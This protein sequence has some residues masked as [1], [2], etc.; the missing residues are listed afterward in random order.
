MKKLLKY[1][2][3]LLVTLEH[4]SAIG[5]PKI[6][7]L[8]MEQPFPLMGKK[9]FNRMTLKCQATGNPM[10][11]IQ[12]KLNGKILTGGRYY[13]PPSEGGESQLNVFSVTRAD[14]GSYRC[15]ATNKYGTIFN[16]I[17]VKIYKMGKFNPPYT[18]YD[19]PIKQE[20]H[21]GKPL[22][23]ACPDHDEGIGNSYVWGSMP[24]SG[25]PT[26][27]RSG[28]EP[29]EDGF[30]SSHGELVF[31]T[32]TSAKVKLINDM[33]GV[34][35][36][37]YRSEPVSSV[38][39]QL[40]VKSEEVPVNSKPQL[41]RMIDADMVG[42]TGKNKEM[43]CG[44][45]G[46]PNPKV[47]W[48]KDG[49]EITKLNT[50][51]EGRNFTISGH[52]MTLTIRPITYL[53]EGKYK[54]VAENSEG[55]DE[56]EGFLR[57]H[58]KPYFKKD[59]DVLQKVLYDQSITLNCEGTGK[60]QVTFDWYFNGSLLN[61]TDRYDISG[62]KLTILK[63]DFNHTGLYLCVVRN[64]L[65]LNVQPAYVSVDA[66]PPSIT[67]GLDK[68][69]YIFKGKDNLLSCTFYSAPS[70]LITWSKADANIS[71]S[72]EK[73]MLPNVQDKD[74]GKYT[75]HAKNV[76]GEDKDV[77]QVYAVVETV[78]TKKPASL[79]KKVGTKMAQL[80]CDAV[81]EKKYLKGTFQWLRNGQPFT[82]S[83]NVYLENRLT[84]P[85]R[86]MFFKDIPMSAAG[87]YTCRVYAEDSSRRIISEDTAV[88]SITV[89]GKPKSPVEG[90]LTGDCDN[91][92]N[93]LALSWK[94][95]NYYGQNI[96]YYILEF[97]ARDRSADESA[98]IRYDPD[99]KIMDES[100]DIEV[101][102]LPP[103]AD[104]VFR[105][106]SVIEFDDEIFISDPLSVYG[107]CSTPA[108]APIW[109]PKIGS[110]SDGPGTLTVTWNDVDD[111]MK[112]GPGFAI[113]VD[114]KKLPD[115]E[116]ITKTITNGNKLV[117]DNAGE[118]EEYEVTVRAKNDHGS[119]PEVKAKLKSSG[120]RITSAPDG[121]E[122]EFD[123]VTNDV[124]I[125]WKP[126]EGA[127]KYKVYYSAGATKRRR[128][129][130]HGMKEMVVETVNATLLAKDL[131]SE[132][133]Y[134]YQIAGAND[135]MDGPKS[136]ES[137]FQTKPSV[138][139]APMDADVNIIG[140][141]IHVTWNPPA[142]ERTKI[143]GYVVTYYK[144][145][146]KSNKKT[147]ECDADC[148]ELFVT[149]GLDPFSYYTVE[150]SAKNENGIGE[151]QVFDGLVV[152]T[153]DIPGKPAP[154][155]Y[156]NLNE[157]TMAINFALPTKGYVG[158][159][160]KTFT[161]HYYMHGEDE[162]T[163]LKVSAEF[164]SRENITIHNVEPQAYVLFAVGTNQAGT[165]ERSDVTERY[166][167]KRVIPVTVKDVPSEPFYEKIWFLILIIIIALIILI[168]LII[169]CCLTRRGGKYPVDEKE[170]E[171][172]G[173][174]NAPLKDYSEVPMDEIASSPAKNGKGPIR[175]AS[176]NSLKPPFDADEDEDKD[177][178]DD[179][180]ED[181]KFNEDG[182]FIGQYGG[183]DAKKSNTVNGGAVV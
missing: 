6:T 105:L 106:K 37:L 8:E 174:D 180:G 115:G 14:E 117:I 3:T 134:T 165:G 164:P 83:K 72:G 141:G 122:V 144:D 20:A 142:A 9:G 43:I 33:G 60:P 157:T 126:V 90:S 56:K 130:A 108:G 10:P 55:K 57:V 98:W 64:Y 124:I 132:T 125:S 152:S 145:G 176:Q 42:V 101:K 1:I 154:P 95:D 54:C 46:Y 135:Y 11:T 110:E 16:E 34:S 178:L 136:P 137:T 146:D 138:P 92:S 53:A 161:I 113:V 175:S 17:I 12:W 76:K 116:T 169:C 63:A 127:T 168:A 133:S 163:A 87:G 109:V 7:Y 61:K 48:Y 170:R 96:S 62:G 114:Y 50:N 147:M 51:T 118:N 167:V 78:I 26:M 39:I 19:P 183:E 131:K 49:V 158:G 65:G 139:K 84:G 4:A 88:G 47:T 69:T 24:D 71:S 119:G 21:I 156:V 59:M 102:K 44:A 77:A 35:C 45:I 155:T 23:L 36:I 148:R 52:G 162:S 173:W 2:T 25:T 67:S 97:A 171:R 94:Q 74:T 93:S 103:S 177:S 143:T 58:S 30:F 99:T 31:S 121:I 89:I 15:E 70:S 68:P 111:V 13:T 166:P 151:P 66:I 82:S 73:L 120:P 79:T 27:W 100:V 129:D 81:Y 32:L 128:R 28:T 41:R 179:Y 5:I 85:K 153:I 104:L 80:Y 40:D 149:E 75:C 38:Q 181:T 22:E 107:A 29:I 91:S 159:L 123:D 140:H 18:R 172:G 150:L 112:A 182:S 160:P 86:I